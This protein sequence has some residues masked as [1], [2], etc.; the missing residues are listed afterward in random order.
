MRY[1]EGLCLVLVTAAVVTLFGE[2]ALFIRHARVDL[3]THS[4]EL[5]QTITDADRTVIIAGGTARDIELEVRS[6]RQQETNL[7]AQAQKSTTHLDAA[8]VTLN[9]LESTATASL[10]SQSASLTSLEDEAGKSIQSLTPQV[11]GILGHLNASTA[12]LDADI[13]APDVQ[14]TERSLSQ[15]ATNLASTTAHIDGTTADIQSFTHRELAPVKGTWN[16]LK[17]F[18][19]EIASPASNVAVALK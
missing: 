11:Q 19:M 7:I 1:L 17:K 4:K 9:S 5:T 15:T 13:S 6:W 14:S 12:A 2:G 16:L 18:L 10:A 3:D 8:I